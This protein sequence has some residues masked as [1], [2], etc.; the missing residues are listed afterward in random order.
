[1]IN[2]IEPLVREGALS[3]FQLK[4][5]QQQLN[6]RQAQIIE[7]RSSGIIEYDRQQ[8]TIKTLLSDISRLLEE[9]QT[10]KFGYSSS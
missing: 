10:V 9:Q 3:E 8:Q 7:Q 5:R 1:M 6:D 2:S 4:T